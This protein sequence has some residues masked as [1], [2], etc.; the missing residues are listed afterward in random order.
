VGF[1]ALTRTDVRADLNQET[2]AMS[3]SP[4]PP[5]PSALPGWTFFSR[6]KERTDGLAVAPEAAPRPGAHGRALGRTR[7]SRAG[8]MLAGQWEL[9]ERIGAGGMGEVYAATCLAD[10]R[11]YAVKLLGAEFAT[12]P[13]ML[14][15][16]LH[17]FWVLRQ[18]SHPHIVAAHAYFE[19]G[20]ER[21][22]SME[23]LRGESLSEALDHGP[24]ELERGLRLALQLCAAV[25][26]LHERG[27]IHRDL[28]PGNVFVTQVHGAEHVKLLDLGI[29]KLTARWYADAELRTRPELRIQTQAGIVVGTPGYI[30]PT[31]DEG[32]FAS[33]VSLDVFGLGV[34]LFRVFV[35]RLPYVKSPP[36]EDDE[37]RWYPKDDERIPSVLANVLKKAIAP[38]P[39]L[40]FSSIESLR[41]ELE[42]AAM[43]IGA[44]PCEPESS[45]ARDG[46]QARPIESRSVAEGAEHANEQAELGESRADDQSR[47]TTL[48]RR[49]PGWALVALL[50]AYVA[51]D[52]G[53]HLV[54]HLRGDAETEPQANVVTLAGTRAPDPVAEDPENSDGSQDPV[55]PSAA[56]TSIGASVDT[57]GEQALTNPEPPSPVVG[58]E[59]SVYQGPVPKKSRKRL[60]PRSFRTTAASEQAA[61]DRCARGLHDGPDVDAVVR[62]GADGKV[63]EI[64]LEPDVSFLAQSCVSSVFEGLTFPPSDGPSTHSWPL[65]RG[66]NGEAGSVEP[67]PRDRPGAER[68]R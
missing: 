52:L 59:A 27:V 40:R 26:A 19:D 41:D 18:I 15:R 55:I 39:A 65:H 17:E 7:P 8:S 32:D 37:P 67:A 48:P 45:P 2:R 3:M 47:R 36:G 49:G 23:L 62:V 22:Y 31:S 9:R 30:G 57:P 14:T 43:E 35:G 60:T 29:C 63:S 21:Y 58:V 53:G 33:D 10:R 11:P 50:G 68:S 1:L 64:R 4:S 66:E 16:F 13:T 44:I 42:Q 20:G 24:L 61:L 5:M 28:K 12:D 56:S 25:T 38:D 6:P 34:T 46:N 54:A 51:V